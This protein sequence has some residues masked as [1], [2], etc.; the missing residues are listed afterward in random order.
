M[1]LVD[2]FDQIYILHLD[3]LEDRKISILNQIEKYE[4]KNITIIDALNKKNINIEK[5]KDDG[6]LAYGGNSYCKTHVNIDGT[7]C[8]CNGAGHKDVISKPGRVAIAFSHYFAYKDMLK[9]HYEKCLILED[10]FILNKNIHMLWNKLYNDIPYDWEVIYFCNSRYVYIPCPI[11]EK[12]NSKFVKTFNGVSDAGCYAITKSTAEKFIK[13]F[14][15]VRATA[16]G[17]ICVNITKFKDISNV[18]V[19][20]HDLS[21]NGSLGSA[22]GK[23]GLQFNS[24]NDVRDINGNITNKDFLN[25]QLRSK[26]NKYNSI[27]F[28]SK[29]LI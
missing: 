15:P 19:Y 29:Y 24:V 11:F 21:T 26:V 13:N 4:L 20:R 1:K 22:C 14:F 9:N 18:Y 5:M 23:M 3:S 25:E 27:D 10:D 7:K 28:D 17:F 2:Y 6:L 16:D 8:W 12:I